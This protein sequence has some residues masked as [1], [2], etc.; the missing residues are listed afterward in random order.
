M[1]WQNQAANRPPKYPTAG[2][3]RRHRHCTLGREALPLLREEGPAATSSRRYNAYVA[4]VD[5][6]LMERERLSPLSS[7]S[8][9]SEA[10]VVLELF[11]D[12][13]NSGYSRHFRLAERTEGGAIA[14]DGTSRIAIEVRPLIEVDDQAWLAAREVLR[15]RLGEETPGAYALWVPAGAQ[16][17]A[18][19]PLLSDFA[20]HF[21]EAAVRLGPHERS[22]VPLPVTLLLRKNSDQGNVVSVSGGLNM[23]WARFTDLVRGTYDLDSTRLHRLPESEEHLEGLIQRIVETSKQMSAGQVAEIETIDAWTVQRLDGEAGV[24]IIGAPPTATAD[25][26]LAVRRNFRRILVEAGP[27][28]R[29]TNVEFRALIVIGYYARME[30]EGATTAMRGYDPALYAGLDFI[31]LAAD[32]LVKPLIQPAAIPQTPGGSGPQ[33]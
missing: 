29:E 8:A 11:L 9:M 30:Q 4:G 22:H 21:R 14:E 17:P 31:C 27:A 20:A 19:E 12:W 24:A 16:L 2:L 13:L 32:G 1:H 18:G 26:G 3:F 23:H 5:T 15:Q 28:L 7:H 10:T 6:R 33:P 25:M